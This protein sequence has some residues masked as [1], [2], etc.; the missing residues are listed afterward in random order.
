MGPLS[1]VNVKN[2]WTTWEKFLRNSCDRGKLLT[3]RMATNMASQVET[4][5]E[6]TE[7]AAEL[8][9]RIGLS[10]N[11]TTAAQVTSSPV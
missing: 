10:G 11:L 5:P 6:E 3:T 8:Y 7:E 4:C 1:Q 9:R 2:L